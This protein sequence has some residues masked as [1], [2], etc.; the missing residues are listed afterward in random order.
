MND[1]KTNFFIKEEN[2]NKII[3]LNNR[4]NIDK[5]PYYLSIKKI[6]NDSIHDAVDFISYLQIK[7][8]Q[9]FILNK[10][11]I[12][13]I[14]KN[15]LPYTFFLCLSENEALE[16]KRELYRNDSW[17]LFIVVK[18]R[19]KQGICIFSYTNKFYELFLPHSNEWNNNVMVDFFQDYLFF[20]KENFNQISGVNKEDIIDLYDKNPVVLFEKLTLEEAILIINFFN[21]K[22]PYLPIDLMPTETRIM[23]KKEKV[24]WNK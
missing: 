8:M 6:R 13:N 17:D 11:T 12:K 14:L 2:K 9:P 16:L 7:Y 10:R 24:K 19:E 20:L 5:R 3:K 15:F 23:I 18:K 21:S 4:L 22:Y 1:A